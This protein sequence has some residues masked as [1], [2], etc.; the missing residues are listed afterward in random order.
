LVDFEHTKAPKVNQY[1]EEVNN[2]QTEALDA[3]V[4]A[5]YGDR[6]RADKKRTS[7][8]HFEQ[9][10]Y[11][12]ILKHRTSDR[13]KGNKLSA[14]WA[15]PYRVLDIDYELENLKVQLPPSMKN[16]HPWYA[17]DV[18]KRYHGTPPA[19]PSDEKMEKETGEYEVERI[20]NHKIERGMTLWLVRWKGYTEDD[21]TWEP[22]GNLENAREAIMEYEGW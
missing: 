6:E 19:Q 5:R 9:D 16:R 3:L 15:G 7:R 17:I 10:D 2:L 14:V 22:D 1:L 4:M 8:E 12:L 20:I 21:D 18:V 11:V 13:K